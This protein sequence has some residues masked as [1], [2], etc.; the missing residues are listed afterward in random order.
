MGEELN[1]RTVVNLPGNMHARPGPARSIALTAEANALADAIVG[2]LDRIH[3]WELDGA[4]VLLAGGDLHNVNAEVL[5]E[6]VRANFVSKHI[7]MA[8]A[9]LGIEYRPVEVG[10]LVVRTLLTAPVRDGGLVG[11]VPQAAMEAPR[12]STEPVEAAVISNPIEDKAGKR[13]LMKHAGAGGERTRQEI[14][15]G[16]QRSAEFQT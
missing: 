5:R 14:A 7:V 13:A 11:R 15:R 4:L 12:Q 16:Q 8:G 1:N 10:E 3:L 6:I 9:G 2:A